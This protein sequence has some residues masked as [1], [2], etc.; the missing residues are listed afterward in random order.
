MKSVS[1]LRLTDALCGI[2]KKGTLR[3]ERSI[4]VNRPIGHTKR[5]FRCTDCKSVAVET[6]DTRFI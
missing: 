6:L 3:L 4:P 5:Q 2:C 1:T